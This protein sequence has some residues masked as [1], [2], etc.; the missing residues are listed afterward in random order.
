MVAYCDYTMYAFASQQT[1]VTPKS[2]AADAARRLSF[3]GPANCV[4]MRN[5]LRACARAAQLRLPAD[6]AHA[7]TG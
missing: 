3:G 7:L 5:E 4:L 6:D 1:Y 2:L